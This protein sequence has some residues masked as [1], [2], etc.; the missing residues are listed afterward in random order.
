MKIHFFLENSC[1]QLGFGDS[2][3]IKQIVNGLKLL[4]VESEVSN[5]LSHVQQ[6][7]IVFLS[8]VYLDLNPK[9]QLL[10]LLSKPYHLIPFY[11][12]VSH[13]LKSAFGFF[14]FHASKLQKTS[15]LTFEKFMHSFQFEVRDHNKLNRDV[16]EGA[17]SIIANTAKEKETILKD[18]PNKRVEV[19]HWAA[20]QKFDTPEEAFTSQYHLLKKE[21]I[22][23]VGRF[24]PRKNQIASILS[25]KKSK[26]P[27]VLISSHIFKQHL[28]YVKCCLELARQARNSP[29]IIFSQ[30][31]ENED[32]PNLKVHKIK[33]PLSKGQLLNAYKNSALHIH[34][35][36]YELPGFTTL[37]SAKLGIPTIAS[38]WSTLKSYL[39][40]NKVELSDK[41]IKYVDPTD[42]ETMSKL[43][44]SEIGKSYS[45]LIDP[46]YERGD[47]EVAKEFNNIYNDCENRTKPLS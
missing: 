38:N 7:D 35:A 1:S 5:N 36:F 18:Y 6:A 22:I 33:A 15:P 40:E 30:D 23:Q 12:D 9:M 25:T 20:G 8:N 26:V 13:Y 2:I 3:V 17:Q 29:V 21:Y 27:L 16:I 4:G 32:H 37:E 28:P 47:L 46:L 24:E 31:L 11:E 41:R 44:D 39:L 14:A 19:I 42:I 10:K 34:P 45:K 43:V